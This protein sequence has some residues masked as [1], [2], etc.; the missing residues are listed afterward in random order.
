MFG[1]S[2]KLACCFEDLKTFGVLSK[3]KEYEGKV[4]GGT[5][6]GPPVLL[7]SKAIETGN[8]NKK[9]NKF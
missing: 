4:G 3:I 1:D 2:A 6:F 7:I 5:A 8:A 9:S